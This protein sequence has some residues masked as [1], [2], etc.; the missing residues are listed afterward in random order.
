MHPARARRL[1]LIIIMLI[2]VS[3]AA[4]LAIMAFKENLMLYYTPTE[5][6]EGK[7]PLKKRFNIAGM[8]VEG[9]V[10]KSTSSVNVQFD[11]TD[12]TKTVTV[13]FDGILPD[14]FREGQAIIAKGNM[15]DSR[16]FIADIVLAKHDENY[17]PKEVADSLKN[18]T[19][20][21]TKKPTP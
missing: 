19:K 7:P 21:P 5:V 16:L 11:L 14:L 2:G 6:A 8:V 12:Y 10:K 15:N 1:K 3:I 17:M 18:K 20:P 13:S 9:S 4:A